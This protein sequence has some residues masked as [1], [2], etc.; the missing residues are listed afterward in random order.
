MKNFSTVGPRLGVRL[1][2]AA[3]LGAAAAAPVL[4]ADCQF[5]PNA[6]D[7]HLVVKG[8][9]LWGISGTFLE[10]P[11][12]WPQVWGMNKE[13]IHNPHWIYPGQIVYF[14]RAHGRLSLRKPGDGGEDSPG[15]PP[16]TRLSPQLRTE[17]LGKDAVQ[18]IPSGVIEPFLSQPLIVEADELKGAPRIAA[19]A[20]G[21]V[22]LGKDDKAYVVG[23]LKG[24]TSFQVY[25]P[26]NPL[27]DPVTGKLVAYEA[28]YL[29]TVKLRVAAKAPGEAHIFTVDSSK[30]EMGTGD[31][32]M[33]AP[34]TP[35]RNY[36]PHQP[37]RPVDAR[38]MSIYGGVSVAGQNAVIS[39]NRGSVDGLD[40]G[41]V[42]QLYHFGKTVVDPGGEKGM[43]G[44]RKPTV[45]LPDE[46][47]GSVFV[48]RVFKHVSYGLVMQVTEP[49]QV[50]DLAKSPE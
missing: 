15:T 42:L 40:I 49:V 29:G 23:D 6:P 11:W 25:R 4:A 34:P 24:G 7:Q 50:G 17:G 46:Q 12:C 16:I 30:Q 10:H 9:T 38:A 3:L 33:P 8:D 1:I 37:E 5:L 35:M 27:N 13:E 22:Y 45:K 26:G 41:A 21:H 43:L 20:E 2:V 28:F 39:L 32:L 14:D 19:T 31:L 48:F 44:L 47:Y 36:V 18:S